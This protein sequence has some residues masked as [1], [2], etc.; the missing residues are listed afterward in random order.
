[1]SLSVYPVGSCSVTVSC[2]V[3]GVTVTDGLSLIIGGISVSFRWTFRLSKLLDSC[4]GIYGFTPY[5]HIDQ[6]TAV[7][8][9]ASPLLWL[10]CCFSCLNHRQEIGQIRD[11]LLQETR[12]EVKP[13][14]DHSIVSFPPKFAHS[15]FHI[16]MA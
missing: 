5:I 10:A 4:F 11:H 16:E 1:M 7:F 2:G 12:I 8:P 3:S 13:A 9:L 14:D 6:P 15:I